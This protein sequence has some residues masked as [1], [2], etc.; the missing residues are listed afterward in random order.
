MLHDIGDNDREWLQACNADNVIDNLPADGKMKPMIVVFPNGN[1][2][3]TA[4]ALN[5]PPGKAPRVAVPGLGLVPL[6]AQAPAA[7]SAGDSKAG[8]SLLRT[9]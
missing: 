3:V 9:T 7:D 2:S 5:A 1:S 6:P 4:D 8:E